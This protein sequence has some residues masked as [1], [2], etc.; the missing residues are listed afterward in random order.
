MRMDTT[1]IIGNIGTAKLFTVEKELEVAQLRQSDA[2]L[3]VDYKIL[4]GEL[5]LLL[6]IVRNRKECWC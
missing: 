5:V 2:K 3:R 6:R 1:M 4:L